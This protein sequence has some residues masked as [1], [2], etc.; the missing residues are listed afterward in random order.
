[1][2]ADQRC[3]FGYRG[4][5]KPATTILTQ[6]RL[7]Q[8]ASPAPA[9]GR[10]QR[11]QT[12]HSWGANGQGKSTLVKTIARKPCSRPG[13]ASITEG[14]G[15]SIGYFAQQEL[16]VLRPEEHPLEHMTRLASELGADAPAASREQDLRNWL[17]S[18][19]FS[20]DMVTQTVGSMS[21]GERPGWCWP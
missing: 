2:L 17:G 16:D 6:I 18:F 1:M 10:A 21:G 9:A 5:P 4:T 7:Q 14:K 3:R 20:G 12:G 13:L 8:A 15:L 19:N 11:H